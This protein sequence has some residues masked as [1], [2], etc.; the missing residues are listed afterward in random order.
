MRMKIIVL[1]YYILIN[2]MTY[3]YLGIIILFFF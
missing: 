2:I 1:G 3:M